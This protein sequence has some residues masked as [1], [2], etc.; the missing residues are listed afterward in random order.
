MQEEELADR[1]G[2][3][4]REEDLSVLSAGAG[5]GV[6]T[7][8]RRVCVDE[9]IVI[10]SGSDLGSCWSMRRS[11]RGTLA[12]HDGCLTRSWTSTQG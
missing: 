1:S 8:H 7:S 6:G 11:T 2:L 9:G 5:C 10:D 12:T 3:R 4:L